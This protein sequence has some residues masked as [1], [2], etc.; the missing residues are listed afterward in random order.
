MN[1]SGICGKNARAIGTEIV[2]VA[3][4]CAWHPC[5]GKTNS[6]NV[7]CFTEGRRLE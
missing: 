3:A 4:I 6:S 5:H 2:Q 7:R 1:S